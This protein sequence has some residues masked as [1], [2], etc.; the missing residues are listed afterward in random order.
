MSE[1][2]EERDCENEIFHTS[3]LLLVL[4]LSLSLFLCLYLS[5]TID[6]SSVVVNV[7]VC[8]LYFVLFHVL[9]LKT[10]FQSHYYYYYY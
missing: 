3:S 4:S 8:S 7:Y 10:F 1:R 2:G 9:K 5:S 6:S